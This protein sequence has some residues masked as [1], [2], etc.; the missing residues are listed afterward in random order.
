MSTVHVQIEINAPP[1]IVWETIMNP[2]RLSEWVTIHRSVVVKSDD[3]TAEGA[4]MDQ[5]LH[6]MGVSFKVHWTLEAVRAPREAEWQGRGPA[7]S[8]AVIRY[9]LNGEPDGPTTFDYVNEFH[10][11]GGPLGSVA[12]RIVVGHISE[13][14]AHDSLARLKALVESN[15]SQ[16]L[17]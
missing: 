17:H 8:R 5:V 4:Q 6:V 11:P 16:T 10:P 7:M 14:E 15:W 2:S 9:H 3:P 12:S 13:H 1:R